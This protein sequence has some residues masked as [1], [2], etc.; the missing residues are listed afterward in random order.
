[1][2]PEEAARY[3]LSGEEPA[4]RSGSGGPPSATQTGKKLTR[5]EGEVAKLVARG[6]T[7]RQIA[8]ELFVSER[9]VATHVGRILKKL[10]VHSRDRVKDLLSDRGRAIP[11][12]T[13]PPGERENTHA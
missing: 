2:A 5:R 6:L 10:G 8:S 11:R 13:A 12:S 7:N 4:P 9:T 3:A 1:M